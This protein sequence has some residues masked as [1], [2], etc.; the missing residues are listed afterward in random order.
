MSCLLV[1]D[2]DPFN[3][4]LIADHLRDENHELVFA[5]D[6]VEAWDILLQNPGRFDAVILDRL[7]PRRDGIETL[8][9]IKAD[10]RFAAVPVVMQ[11]AASDPAEVAEGLAAGAWYYLAKPYRRE[12][13]K[14]IVRAALGDRQHRQDLA[15]LSTEVRDILDMMH[16][17]RFL[18]RSPDQVRELAAT[19]ARACPNEGAVAMGLSELMLNAVEHGNLGISYDDKSRLMETGTW[20]EE[21]E[22][23]LAQPELA[24]RH[25]VLE[26]SR[27][28]DVMRFTIR[29]EGSGFDW[30]AYLEFDPERAFHSHGR[31]IAMSRQVSFA[32]LEYQGRGNVVSVTVALTAG[33]AD[34]SGKGDSHG[35]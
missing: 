9:L 21:V 6:G 31:G 4:E 13:L 11:T 30:R 1:V 5:R 10:P 35:I 7:M 12:A 32:S 23:R 18:F 34:A 20:R 17:A 19:L 14:H 22:R 2:D 28:A 24:A 3:L 15:R 25:G 27:E 33:G 26:L 16:Q 8:R 29:D